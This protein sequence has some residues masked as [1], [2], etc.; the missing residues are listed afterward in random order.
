MRNSA[1]MNKEE[2]QLRKILD[3]NLGC[4]HTYTVQLTTYVCLTHANMHTH[5]YPQHT[6]THKKKSPTLKNLQKM[7][8]SGKYSTEITH[9]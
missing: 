2:E 8:S 9:A 6:N 3:I 7:N 1:L 5:M 4:S